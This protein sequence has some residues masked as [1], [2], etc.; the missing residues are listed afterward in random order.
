LRWFSPPGDGEVVEDHVDVDVGSPVE[1]SSQL[2]GNGRLAGSRHARDEVDALMI[3]GSQVIPS[4]GGDS[5]GA[6]TSLS[7]SHHRS[8]LRAVSTRTGDHRVRHV[9]MNA[10]APARPRFVIV[11]LP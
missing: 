1:A 3:R 10:D 5:V 8:E 6:Y 7:L 4:T 9:H 11:G 2:S